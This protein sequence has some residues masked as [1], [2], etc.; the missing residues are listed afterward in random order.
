MEDWAQLVFDFMYPYEIHEVVLRT[1][2]YTVVKVYDGKGNLLSIDSRNSN[3]NL[4]L[5][6]GMW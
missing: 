4:T 2:E 5:R 6:F 3:G 1:P